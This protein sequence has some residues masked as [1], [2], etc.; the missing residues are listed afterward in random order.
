MFQ[1]D[2]FSQINLVL[3]QVLMYFDSD[4]DCIHVLMLYVLL[5]LTIDL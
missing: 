5:Y 4:F 3:L 2:A 1:S